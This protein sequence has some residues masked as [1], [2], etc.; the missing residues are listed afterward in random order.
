[1]IRPLH[2]RLKQDNTV[3]FNA[4]APFSEIAALTSTIPEPDLTA[5]EKIPV[6]DAVDQPNCGLATR[7]RRHPQSTR[8]PQRPP[9]TPPS[10]TTHDNGNRAISFQALNYLGLASTLG[11]LHRKSTAST[12]TQVHCFHKHVSQRPTHHRGDAPTEGWAH[13]PLL[14]FCLSASQLR[15]ALTAPVSSAAPPTSPHA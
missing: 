14:L 6:D 8:H 3:G 12:N 1:M 15:R 2:T 11:P 4:V 5:N 7:M 13:L 10:L 9:A